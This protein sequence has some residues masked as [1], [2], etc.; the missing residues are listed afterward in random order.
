[1]QQ[2]LRESYLEM[3]TTNKAMVAPVGIAFARSMNLDSTLNLYSPDNSHPSMQGTYLAACVFYASIFQNSPVGISYVAGLN[4][5]TATFL[6]QVAHNVVLDSLNVWNLNPINPTSSFTF[7]QAANTF[8]FSNNSINARDYFWDFG[9]GNIS[10][11]TNPQH[12]YLSS[13][14]F[15]VELVAGLRCNYDSLSTQVSATISALNESF[16]ENNLQ[17]VLIDQ[18]L[19]ILNLHEKTANIRV[20][21]AKGTLVINSIVTATSEPIAVRNLDSGLYFI[22]W[23]NKESNGV[24]KLFVP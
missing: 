18:Q 15:N 3:A 16:A 2:R 7:N 13:G 11:E 8:N 21:D 17:F 9:D 5:G 1:M 4:Q 6:Q 24:Q 14:N 19:N 12:T 22:H 10:T 20:Y 23:L